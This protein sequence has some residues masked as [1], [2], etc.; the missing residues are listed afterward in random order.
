MASASSPIG[1]KPGIDIEKAVRQRGEEILGLMDAA[2][3]PSLFSRKG[4]YGTLMDWAMRDDH[5]KTQL[6]RFVDVLPTLS[7][8]SEVGRH[9]KEYLQNDQVKL[10]PALRTALK[11]AGSASW[12]LGAGVKTQVTAMAR[13]FMLGDDPK[14]IAATLRQLAERDVG[15][16]VDI[17][18]ETVVS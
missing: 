14:E 13:Q 10:A 16:T 8:S 12:L 6:F 5:F 11:A 4:F 1:K 7:S 17:L 9:L 15:F 18:G 2:D 3:S